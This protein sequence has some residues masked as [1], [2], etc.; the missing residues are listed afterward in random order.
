VHFVGMDAVNWLLT[1]HGIKD[2][3]SRLLFATS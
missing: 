1:M 2:I 3:K